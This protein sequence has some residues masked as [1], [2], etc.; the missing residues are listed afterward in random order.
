[1]D[2]KNFKPIAIQA[3]TARRIVSSHRPVERKNL[4]LNERLG[5]VSLIDEGMRLGLAD[6]PVVSDLFNNLWELVAAT[7][8]GAKINRNTPGNAQNGFRVL[9]ISAES[10]EKL[11]RLNMLYLKKPLPC[12]YLVYV[13]VAVPYRKRGLGNQILTHFADFLSS[14]SAIGILDNIIPN[15]DPTY[16]IY[17]KHAWN[18]VEDIIGES[19]SGKDHNYMIYLP[20]GFENKDLKEPILKLLYHLG[21]KRTII[22][23]RDNQMMVKRTIAEFK[24]LYQTLTTYFETELKN[25]E[26][27]PFMRFMFTRFVTK[28]IAFRRRIGNLLGYTGGESMMQITVSPE[29]SRLKLKSYAPSELETKNPMVVGDLELL[30]RIR[31]DFKIR[32]ARTVE[33]LPNY[34]RPN[35]KTWLEEREKSFENPLTIGDI[36]DLGF[37]PTRLKEITIDGQEFIFERVQARQIPEIMKKNELLE[38][39]SIKMAQE[40]VRNT[41]VRTNPALLIFQDRGNAYVLRSKIDAIHWEEALEQVQSHPHLKELNRT[42]KMDSIIL[43]TV[44]EAVEAITHK[45]GLENGMVL[46][47]LSPFISWDLKNNQPKMMIDFSTTYLESAWMA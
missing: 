19:P 14:K 41:P 26:S 46:D 20:R 27:S 31:D 42:V 40:K 30:S 13:E 29:V 5:L 3:G 39:I 24:E 6:A 34:R 38:H 22:D 16:D 8:S 33:S 18:P 15:D 43:S 35:L 7:A 17:L 10:G 4:S 28:L 12:Y 25:R 36:M 9:E 37:D 11:G 45:L 23:M 1:M 44:K 47:Q 32:P 21:R 2:Q